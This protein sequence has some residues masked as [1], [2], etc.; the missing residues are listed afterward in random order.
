MRSRLTCRALAKWKERNI[1]ADNTSTI[2]VFFDEYEKAIPPYIPYSPPSDTETELGEATPS[3]CRSDS[4][5]SE[6]VPQ[7]KRE[8]A[9]YD[10]E[11]RKVKKDKKRQHSANFDEETER[12]LKRIVLSDD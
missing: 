9:F 5:S 6:D 4:S 12:E 11:T 2:V 1:R 10:N 3:L 7:L 8:F